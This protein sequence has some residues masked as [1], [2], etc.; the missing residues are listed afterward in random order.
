MAGVQLMEKR[1]C[2]I[3]CTESWFVLGRIQLAESRRRIVKI[4]SKQ[5]GVL[6]ITRKIRIPEISKRYRQHFE[7]E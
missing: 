1:Y 4:Y 7:N 6:E 5:G 3:H 2:D